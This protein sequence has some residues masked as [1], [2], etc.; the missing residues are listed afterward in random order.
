MNNIRVLFNNKD[1]INIDIADELNN[2]SDLADILERISITIR[3]GEAQKK[4][5]EET[6]C[7]NV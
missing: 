5:V 2:I 3:I 1:V 7:N 4:E 6:N